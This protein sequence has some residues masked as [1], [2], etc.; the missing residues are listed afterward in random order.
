M[1]PHRAK[2][3]L[4]KKEM[5]L[6]RLVAGDDPDAAELLEAARRAARHRVAVKRWLHAPPLGPPPAVQYKGQSIRY[7][8]Y[9]NS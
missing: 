5:R 3:A 4:S 2:S 8:V 9:L 1:F 7:D 6:C